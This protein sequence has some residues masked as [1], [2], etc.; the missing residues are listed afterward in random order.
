MGH[1]IRTDLEE[2]DLLVAN[3]SSDAFLRDLDNPIV[4]ECKNWTRK[5]KVK[6]IR[7]FSSVMESKSVHTGVFIAAG[8]YTRGYRRLIRELRQHA[9]I[10]IPLDGSD[11]ESVCQG[12]NLTDLMRDRFYESFKW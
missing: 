4:V 1:N 2:I 11:I 6:E 9:R 7:I 10:I 8:S 3:E 5:T 12:L